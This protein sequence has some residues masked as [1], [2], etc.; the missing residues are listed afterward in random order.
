M[1]TLLPVGFLLGLSV[2]SAGSAGEAVQLERVD[3][4]TEV[5]SVSVEELTR[6]ARDADHPVVIDVRLR[7]DFDAEPVLIPDASWRDPNAID[8]WVGE[9]SPDEPV[10]VYCVRGRW[11]SQS[12]TKKLRDM[13]LN[14]AQ[15]TGGI[16]AWKEAGNPTTKAAR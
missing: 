9:L 4:S 11:V 15:L 5:P 2:S 10:V 16:E 7:E 13:G 14:V 8:S 3:P 12:V 1:S 6:A